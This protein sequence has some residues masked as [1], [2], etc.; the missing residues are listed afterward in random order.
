VW[1]DLFDR[2]YSKRTIWYAYESASQPL[3]F[4]DGS[5]NV[6]ATHFANPGWQN[7]AGA[8]FAN[9]NPSLVTYR[10]FNAT[11]PAPLYGNPLQDRRPQYYRW[12]RGG[13]RGIDFKG[14]EVKR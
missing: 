8:Q 7:Q 11:D 1:F 10:T 3:A 2:H 12:T 9:P 4:F 5:V 6:G 13:L 14:Q